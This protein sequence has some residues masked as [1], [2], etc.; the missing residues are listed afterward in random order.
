MVPGKYF[1]EGWIYDG[2]YRPYLGKG[3]VGSPVHL[4]DIDKNRADEQA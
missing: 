1:V 4:M 2:F 3:R